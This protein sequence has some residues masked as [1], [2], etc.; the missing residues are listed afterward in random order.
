MNK[1]YS[2]SDSNNVQLDLKLDL[3]FNKKE[4]GFY[5]E[6]DAFDGISQSNTAFFEFTCK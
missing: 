4:N 6:L 3:L 2:L 5:I 1:Y